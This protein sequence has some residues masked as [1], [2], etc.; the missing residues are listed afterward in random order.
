MNPIRLGIVIGA[1]VVVL[2]PPLFAQGVAF[3]PVVGALPSGP[4]LNTTPAVSIDRR[5]VR[6]GVNAQFIDNA[7]FTT[8]NVPGAVSGGPGGP[9]ALG[10]AGLGGAGAGQFLAGMDG[11]VDPSAGYASAGIPAGPGYMGYPAPYQVPPG[12]DVGMSQGPYL[13]RPAP[14]RASR[15]SVLKRGRKPPAKKKQPVSAAAAPVAARARVGG[16]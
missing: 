13:Q 2:S 8:I 11:V 16:Q 1:L 4:F 12:W 6:V 9:G 15:G 14:P 10:G 5:Y 3:Q 7:A